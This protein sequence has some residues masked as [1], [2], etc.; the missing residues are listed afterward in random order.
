MVNITIL[1]RAL[2]QLELAG[3]DLIR[4]KFQLKLNN[5]DKTELFADPNMITTLYR[6]DTHVYCANPDKCHND[7]RLTK[8]ES[9]MS[10]LSIDEDE[11]LGKPTLEVTGT[12]NMK[13]EV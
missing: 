7:I 4:D 2:E 3:S 8:F 6:C 1:N 9:F 5:T 13:I 10:G 12:I 11:T